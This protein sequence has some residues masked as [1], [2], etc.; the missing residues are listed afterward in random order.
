MTTLPIR[1]AFPVDEYRARLDKIRMDMERRGID[2]LCLTAPENIFYV[3]GYDGWS[4]Y[5]H[6][7]AVIHRDHDMPLWIGR[8]I[9]IPCAQV[10][11]WIG[12]DQIIG[13]GDDYVDN[14]NKHAMEFICDVLKQRGWDRGTVGFEYENYYFSARAYLC[15]LAGLPNAKL[16]DATKLVNWVRAVKSP[17]EIAYMR[18][19]GK[20]ADATMAAGVA[21]VAPGVRESD[22]AA[23]F[24]GAQTKGVDGLAGDAQAEVIVI[25]TGEE[26]TCPHLVWTERPLPDSG[27]I[28]VELSGVRRRYTAAL[29]RSLHLGAAPASLKSLASAT[30]DALDQTLDFIRPGVTG[31]DVWA[32]YNGALEKYGEH[33]PSRTGYSIGI[34]YTPSWIERTMSF[35]KD[36]ASVLEPNMT[37]HLMCGMWRD[38][39]GFVASETLLITE[40]GC[41]RLTRYPKGLIEI[42]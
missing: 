2:V 32:A 22:V 36:D 41:E 12:H 26:V 9:D 28:N 8:G 29:S 37:F 20:V 27:P 23:V 17:A 40:T 34:G 1:H 19:A 3:T 7:V 15:L 24:N 18:Q 16:V 6:Q 10:T 30:L 5:T 39:D 31:H 11:C 33:K 38:T 13:Y 14:D 35:A 21:A 4:F 42:T 25:S